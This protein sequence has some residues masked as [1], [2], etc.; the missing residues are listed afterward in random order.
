[1]CVIYLK[2]KERWNYIQDTNNKQL[3]DIINKVLKKQFLIFQ[4][5]TGRHIPFKPDDI[6]STEITKQ[7]LKQL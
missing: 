4:I 7:T 2:V 3:Q 6:K 5:Q 1:M